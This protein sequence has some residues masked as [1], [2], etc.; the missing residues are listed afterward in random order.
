[1]NRVECCL[2]AFRT[3]L[4]IVLVAGLYFAPP[5]ATSAAST[6]PIGAESVS[7]SA[8]FATGVVGSLT[9]RAMLLATADGEPE[10]TCECTKMMQA[11]STRRGVHSV[12]KTFCD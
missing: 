1:M 9:L 5:P 3:A 8:R 12:A 4:L 7:A 11:V 10:F 2:R 6:G